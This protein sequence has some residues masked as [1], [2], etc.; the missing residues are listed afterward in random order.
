ML[1]LMLMLRLMLMLMLMLML[2][3]LQLLPFFRNCNT[4]CASAATCI[5]SNCRSC[6]S[7]TIFIVDTDTAT[8]A[9][10]S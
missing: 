5:H 10:S 7:C 2:L 4:D 3:V 1:M 6:S 8:A 9:A